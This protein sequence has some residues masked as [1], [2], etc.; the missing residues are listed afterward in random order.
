MKDEAGGGDRDHM[1]AP[2]STGLSHEPVPKVQ[3]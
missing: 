2:F 3:P 1:E